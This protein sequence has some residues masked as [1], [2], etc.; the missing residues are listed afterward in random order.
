MSFILPSIGSGIMASP[1]T[2]AGS[3]YSVDFDGVDD[4]VGF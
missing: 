3:I 2:A 1:V 4:Y